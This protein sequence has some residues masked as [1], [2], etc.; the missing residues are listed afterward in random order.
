[1]KA[2]KASGHHNNEIAQIICSCRKNHLFYYE[3]AANRFHWAIQGSN[4][5]NIMQQ[6]NWNIHLYSK[7]LCSQ[8]HHNQSL[9]ITQKLLPLIFDS[10]NRL[11][12]N[13]V[14]PV[15]S[16]II[17]KSKHLR[18]KPSVYLSRH[19]RNS[20]QTFTWGSESLSKCWRYYRI[21]NN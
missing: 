7:N 4:T 17:S 19:V 10:Y 18:M 1:M 8:I 15:N 11:P 12:L 20:V 13:F 3:T 5:K 16:S 2:I 21:T 6:V 9:D 14:L